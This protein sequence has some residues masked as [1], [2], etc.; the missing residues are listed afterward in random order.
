MLAAGELQSSWAAVHY[1]ENSLMNALFGLAFWEQIFTPVPGAFHNPF[2]GLPPTCTAPTSGCAA[3]TCWS[4]A[5][6]S[7]ARG[8]RPDPAG[9]LHQLFPIPVPLGGL[10]LH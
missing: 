10:A 1:V 9:S 2:Q 3:S 8:A 5:W 7:C 4:D 6:R